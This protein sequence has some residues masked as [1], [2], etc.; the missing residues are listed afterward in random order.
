MPAC[1]SKDA[2][3]PCTWTARPAL[4]VAGREG[5]G[6]IAIGAMSYV[7]E[8]AY[9]F[10]Y[11]R[12]VESQ[13]EARDREYISDCLPR[14]NVVLAASKTDRQTDRR[15]KNSAEESMAKQRTGKILH[16]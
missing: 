8:I 10:L 2:L 6:V 14:S 13:R 7:D 9:D 4:G 3:S 16:G 12:E 1:V 15:A 5:S 11:C